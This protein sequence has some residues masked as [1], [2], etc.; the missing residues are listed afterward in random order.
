MKILHVSNFVQ[1][2]NGRLFWNTP[3]R[4]SNG[5]TRLGHNVLNFSVRDIARENIFNSTKF[6]KSK[7]NERLLTTCINY[8]PDLI[9]LGH[10]D[11]VSIDTL[12][13]IRFKIKKLKIIN[14]NVDHL[15]M[16]DTLNKIK[17]FSKV[18]DST[19]VTTGDKI[20]AGLSNHKMNISFIPNIFD[21]SIDSLKIFE[22]EHYEYDIFFAMSHGVGSGVLKKNKSDGREKLLLH[23][24]NQ[25][26]IN[27]N[28]FGFNN[29]QPIWGNKF[30]QEIIKAPMGLNLSQGK[31]SN[32]YRRE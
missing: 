20:I 3:F 28:F 30:Y 2:D 23:I 24:D 21:N 22:N 11:L 25:D 5:F 7:L 29:I 15:L 17:Y 14:W 4:I 1:K 27:T 26:N 19:F 32:F 9:V 6:G 8:N 31:S 18:V 10:A 16:N 13:E 12:D